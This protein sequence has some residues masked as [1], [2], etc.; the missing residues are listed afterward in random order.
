SRENIAQRVREL[1][2]G[3][4]V[5][6]V[7]DSVGKDTLMASLDSLQ[8]RGHLISNGT[9]SGAVVV[10][11]QLLA[12]KGSI[13][14]TRPAMIHYIHPRA[15]MLDMARELFDHVLA[16]R[17]TSEPRQ[18]FA[19]ADAAQAHRALEARQTAGATVLVP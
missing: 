11:S 17:I 5:K 15:H 3:K 18:T 4:G 10:D 12:Q 2:D 1:T 13:W 16:G 9:S 19:L 14:M 6:V 7:Y 8:P